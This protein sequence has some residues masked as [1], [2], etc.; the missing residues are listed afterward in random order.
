MTSVWHKYS[1]TCPTEGSADVP[2]AAS[3]AGTDG[4]N[5]RLLLEAGEGVDDVPSL[6]THH[7]SEVIMHSYIAWQMPSLPD[8]QLC[9]CS[10]DGCSYVTLVR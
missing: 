7:T 4:C 6:H 8:M 10:T 1:T 2:L 5:A 3:L 9:N